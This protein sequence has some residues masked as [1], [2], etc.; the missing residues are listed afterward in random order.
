LDTY[1]VFLR[2]MVLTGK[3]ELEREIELV[4]QT[5]DWIEKES[6]TCQAC[7]D[8]MT[9]IGDWDNPWLAES[10]EVDAEEAESKD[11]AADNGSNSKASS[12]GDR[13]TA[14][15]DESKA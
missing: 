7:A 3:L 13:E 14:D 4:Q 12:D 1:F 6:E 15:S 9:Q 11:A 8:Y 2:C 5:R 10:E